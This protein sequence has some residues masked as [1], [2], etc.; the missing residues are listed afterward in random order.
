MKCHRLLLL[1]LGVLIATGCSNYTNRSLL[2]KSALVN[3]DYTSALEN[4]EGIDKN[5][6]ELLYY[7]E[8]GLVLHY[9]DAYAE[10]NAAFEQAEIVLDDLYTKSITRE[11]AALAVSDVVA[12]Y[13]GDAHEAV[14]VNYYKIL[15]YLHLNDIEG[16]AIECRR[17]NGKLERIRDAEG[18]Y[19]ENDPFLQYMTAMVYELSGDE[20]D[21][22]VSYRVAVEGFET[23]SARQGVVPPPS[24]YCDAV[25]NAYTMGDRELARSYQ[26]DDSCVTDRSLGL[27]NIFLE[28]GYVDHKVET[29]LQLPILKD[30]DTS[31]DD[32][33]A[34]TLSERRG[35]HYREATIDYWLK[36]ALPSLVTEPLPFDHARTDRP[37]RRR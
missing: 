16:A 32:A 23:L 3:G 34:L 14:L 35:R 7:Y 31:D 30:D 36:V 19:L 27:V 37:K 21:A 2:I 10:S 24:L 9:Q 8:K 5:R 20:E 29:S 25:E 1:V 17:V 11:A 12:K 4:I 26:R 6:S 22:E 28:C 18:D 15:N 13:R 33:F